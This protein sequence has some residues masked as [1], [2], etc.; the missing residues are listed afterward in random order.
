MP[1]A[2]TVFLTPLAELAD[3]LERAGLPVAS[4]EDHSAAHRA[5]AHALVCAFESDAGA[6]AEHIG[7][8]ALDDLLAAHRL[9]ID[10]LD[11]GRVRKLAVV[12]A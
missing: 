9:W 11:S 4:W 10:W 7:S 1:D 2:D 12:A 6:I 5:V 8:R 3:C